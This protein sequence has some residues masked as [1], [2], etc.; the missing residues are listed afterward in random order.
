MAERKVAD[1]E[2]DAL[3]IAFDEALAD[4]DKKPKMPVRSTDDDLDDFLAPLDAAATQKAAA[5][6][7][8]R[9]ISCAFVFQTFLFLFEA[10]FERIRRS[11]SDAK[12]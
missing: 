4:F 12:R 7:Q 3:S 11:S 1:E 6:F 8:V 9:L 10:C 2:A 5:D